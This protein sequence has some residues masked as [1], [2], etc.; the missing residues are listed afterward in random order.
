MSEWLFPITKLLLT[1]VVLNA[2]HKVATWVTDGFHGDA[3]EFGHWGL[4]K[5]LPCGLE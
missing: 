4:G 2:E 1:A 3:R 5:Q